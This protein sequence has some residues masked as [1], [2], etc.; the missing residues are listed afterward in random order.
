[1]LLCT[2]RAL[3]ESG[4]DAPSLSANTALVERG[5]FLEVTVDAVAGADAYR[6]K[7]LDE[8][9]ETRGWA[10]EYDAGIFYV[11]T[12]EAPAGA[13]TLVAEAMDNDGD[14]S[15]SSSAPVPVQVTERSGVAGDICFYVIHREN[16]TVANCLYASAYAPGADYVYI[17]WVGHNEY[18]SDP[19]TPDGMNLLVRSNP[20]AQ[21]FYAVA[22]YPDGTVRH[23]ENVSV[24]VITPLPAG[25][26][27]ITDMPSH[28]A[29]GEALTAS[30]SVTRAEGGPPSCA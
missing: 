23:T 15:V 20:G 17:G 9:G 27:A 6:V 5:D 12:S 10:Y 14:G 21:A 2:G 1:M 24:D 16:P 19:A 22:T 4:I 18:A 11:T 8:N 25:E 26:V 3:A 13:Y 29:E 30:Y 28:L 7:L